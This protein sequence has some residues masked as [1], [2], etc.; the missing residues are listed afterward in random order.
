LT[1]GYALGGYAVISERHP[2]YVLAP[3]A[4]TVW[5]THRRFIELLDRTRPGDVLCNESNEPVAI[6]RFRNDESVRVLPWPAS[7]GNLV[8]ERGSIDRSLTPDRL[9]ILFALEQALRAQEQDADLETLAV[10]VL[11]RR[12]NLSAVLDA[13][14]KA[15]N[16][17]ADCLAIPLGIRASSIVEASL[18]E[19]A[20]SARQLIANVLR[21]IANAGAANP[22]AT[23]HRGE[24]RPL[25][26]SAWRDFVHH[27]E[28]API[29]DDRLLSLIGSV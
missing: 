19:T 10:L 11:E 13:L 16:S 8:A 23:H 27:A 24:L 15:E 20:R 9:L 14:N 22:S 2:R 17:S 29:D 12:T 4:T 28:P 26:R 7:L 3:T 1:D 6:W 5:A 25:G 18:A 21:R